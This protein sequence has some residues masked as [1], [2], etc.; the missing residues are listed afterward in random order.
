MAAAND[1][2]IIE[3]A[4]IAVKNGKIAWLG[5]REQLSQPY[6]KLAANVHHH[7]NYWLTPG[8]ID[9]HT[10]LIYAGQRA[11]EFEMRLQGSSYAAIAQAGGGIMSTVRATRQATAEQ[12]LA[13]AEKRLR[14]LL[15]E[16]VTTVEI[17]SGY[18]LDLNT[19]L[20]LLQV[21][22][23]L[24]EQFPVTIYPTFLGAH[25]LPPEYTSKD[26]YIEMI[27]QDMLPAIS[28]QQ[29]AKAVDVFC[30]SIGFTVQQTARVFETARQYGLAIKCHA[31]QLSNL[32][33]SE[34]AAK[35]QAIS[36][37]H[38][39]YLS[40]DGVAAIAEAG[41]VAVL[42]P[43]AFYT[44]HEKQ[45]PP[46][47]LLREY[48]VPIAIATDCNPGSSPICSLLLML[49]MACILFRLTPYEAFAGVT[50]NAAQALGMAA[51]HG[52]LEIGKAADFALWDIEHPVELAY[53]VGMNPCKVVVKEGDCHSRE[54]GNPGIVPQFPGFPLSRE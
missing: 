27:C 53:Y 54:S 48:Q 35:Y 46:I 38:L 37:D 52:T 43:G 42:L 30:D 32:G 16:G 12:L 18:G 19:E 2:G 21:A 15:R 50:K 14:C 10:H 45:L 33:A 8:L 51:T 3:D 7:D 1:Y 22:K 29:L 4:A 34:L 44:L 40:Q 24:A 17:K 13:N 9:C 36:V 23:Q 39:E 41:T 20:R 47:E 31:E 28:E 11:A 5:R 49:N 6:K 25:A 26:D